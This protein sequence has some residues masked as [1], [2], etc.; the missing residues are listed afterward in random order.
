MEES[1]YITSVA[2]GIFYMVASVRLLRLNRRTGERPELLLGFYFGFSGV[3]Y[4]GYNLPSLLGLESWTSAGDWAIELT[5]VAGVIPYLYFIRTVFR[6]TN[7]WARGLI[8]ICVALLLV[9]TGMG[10]L[11]GRVIYSFDN[12]WFMVQWAGYTIPCAWMGLEAMLCRQGGRKRARLGL[13]D[14]L[15][16]NRYL[17]LALFGGFQVFACLADL[18]LAADIS[19][20]QSASM[21][22][23]ALLGGSEIA[24]VAVL[25]LAFF[26]PLFYTNWITRRAANLSAPSEG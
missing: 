2:A 18:S 9:G 15:V 19:N 21:I 14:P 6:P 7:A 24:S 22:S 26:P 16:V 8:G 10:A 5:Y 13:S 3:Y 20:S 23:D 4:L 25:W 17:L 1:A 11:D 12:P